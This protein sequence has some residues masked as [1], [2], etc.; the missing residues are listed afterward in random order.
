MTNLE[1]SDAKLDESDAKLS[2]FLCHN[3]ET[4]YWCLGKYLTGSL[5][6][7][8]DERID[9]RLPNNVEMEIRPNRVVSRRRGRVSVPG[10]GEDVS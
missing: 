7:N 6:I 5:V 4:P 1:H 3:T 10:A 2:Q 8:E 9:G